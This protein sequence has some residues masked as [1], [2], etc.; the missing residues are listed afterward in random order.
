MNS[1]TIRLTPLAYFFNVLVMGL[2]AAATLWLITQLIGDGNYPMAGMLGA[3][4]TFLCLVY[5]RPRFTPLRWLAVGIALAM[6]FTLYP[7]FYTFYIAFTNMGDGHLL[8]KQQVIERLEA[9]RYLP[10]GGTSFSWAAY[11]SP[12]GEYALWLIAEDGTTFV[13][14][15]GEPIEAA[16]ATDFTLDEAGFP[17]QIDAYQQLSK[18][19]VVPLINELGAIDFGAAA[20]IVRIRSLQEAAT[21]VPRYQYQAEQDSIIN[22]E[23][24][25]VYTPINGT[26]TAPDGE[27]LALGYMVNI[28][29]RNFVRFLTNE[30]LRD[31]MVSI[32]LWNVTFAF[33]SVFLSFAVGLIIALVFEDLWGK[34]I[35]R[36]LLIIPYPIPVLVSVLIWRSI[37]NPDIGIIS[38][39]LENLFGTAPAWFL[40][41]VWAKIALIFINI[42]LSY[43]YFYVI[44]AGALRAIP[45]E[46]N[47]AATVDGASPWQ[48][49]THITLP[50]L[51]RI[52][53]P[54]LIASFTF[55][56]NNFNLIY[57]FNYGNPPMANTIIPVGHTDILISFVYKL[58]FVTSGT[59]DYGLAAAISI[60]LFIIVG[61]F[62]LVQTRF[63]SAFKEA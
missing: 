34:S 14:K 13:A 39:G 59:T 10:E 31:P 36:A 50:L 48:A 55:N 16:A 54:L 57:I 30:A 9:E 27:Q 63:T 35:I 42:W 38:L 60:I 62:T 43:P 7:I 51:L 53:S 6:M 58:A 45:Q 26:F 47:Q 46:I 37:L 18:R 22:L 4:I 11:R 5:L 15:P 61:G 21:L 44:T 25:T 32:L 52:L 12:A 1:N 56:F 29:S 20:T 23:N 41:P 49:F 28:G 17:T 40:N 33:L 2:V 8:A 3:V 19:E 24:G